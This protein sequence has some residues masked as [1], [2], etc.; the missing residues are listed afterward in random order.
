[1]KVFLVG[2]PEEHPRLAS[3]DTDALST[4][5][6]VLGS[7]EGMKLVAKMKN[8]SAVFITKSKRILATKDLESVLSVTD[9]SEIDWK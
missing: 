8:V 7:E 6:F 1:M 5:T 4:A 3:T 9:G 2:I